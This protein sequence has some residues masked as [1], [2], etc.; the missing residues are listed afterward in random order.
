MDAALDEL[1]FGR[2]NTLDLRASLPTGAEA[3]HRAELFLR[4][5]QM[6]SVPEVLVITG[7]GNQSPNGVPVVRPAVEALLAK[8]RRRGVVAGWK[9]H[10]PGSFV[11]TSA[12]ITALLEAP[13]RR[14]DTETAAVLDHGG[15]IALDI[16]TRDALRRLAIRSLQMLGVPTTDSFVH[17]EM[18]RQFSLLGRTVPS[19][20]DRDE[21]LRSA[22]LAAL[23][24]LDDAK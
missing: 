3:V 8:L 10:T 15:L 16:E 22:A 9:E 12:P 24:E 13:R 23:D 18:L 7:R 4:E 21:L 5:R 1:R 11:V 6:A 17:D 20:P 2:A 14:R 19:S